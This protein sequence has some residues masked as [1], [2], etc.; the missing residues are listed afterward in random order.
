MNPPS[1]DELKKKYGIV[2]DDFEVRDKMPSTDEIA[3]RGW[4]QKAEDFSGVPV[5]LWKDWGGNVIAVILVYV[6][7]D[8]AAAFAAPI[9]FYAASQFLDYLQ[10]KTANSIQT[11]LVA[12]LP[13]NTLISGTTGTL[14]F[15]QLPVGTGLFPASGQ[16]KPV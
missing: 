3:S 11:G 12:F 8:L 4:L 2:N 6:F 13:Q 16:Y 15:D 14:L 10:T 7:G 9:V 1:K 5:S